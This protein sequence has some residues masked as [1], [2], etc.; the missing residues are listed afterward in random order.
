M[1][2]LRIQVGTRQ[3]PISFIQQQFLYHTIPYG[4]LRAIL[5][6]KKYTLV[7]FQ[8]SASVKQFPSRNVQFRKIR[9]YFRTQFE[10]EQ[11]ERRKKTQT[12]FEKLNSSMEFQSNAFSR[13]KIFSSFILQMIRTSYAEILRKFAKYLKYSSLTHC[14]SYAPAFI[15]QLQ[16]VI[17]FTESNFFGYRHYRLPIS[18]QLR[19]LNKEGGFIFRKLSMRNDMRT[20]ER[21]F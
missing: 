18:G 6:C 15:V 17:R 8:E 9:L 7:I 5:A 19:F 21:R 20:Y 4:V 1:F 2:V 14:F 12:I 10:R 3:T 16:V 11:T 13:Q